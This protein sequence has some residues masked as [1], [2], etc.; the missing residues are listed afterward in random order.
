MQ[1]DF[2]VFRGLQSFKK[3]VYIFSIFTQTFDF[4]ESV[5]RYFS[6]CSMLKIRLGI[7]LVSRKSFAFQEEKHNRLVYI[8]LYA[9]ISLF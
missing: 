8:S 6:Y 4:F 7:A 1:I 5:M 9:Y 3:N 2:T